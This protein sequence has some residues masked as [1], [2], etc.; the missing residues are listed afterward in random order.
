[1]SKKHV[2][3]VLV[4]LACLAMAVESRL[5]TTAPEANFGYDPP[6]SPEERHEL[7]GDDSDQSLKTA[8][9]ELFE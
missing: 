8:H 1:M 2:L 3:V 4:L 9:P 6:P 7:Y 5:I